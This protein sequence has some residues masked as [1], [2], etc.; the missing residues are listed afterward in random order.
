MYF[1]VTVGQSR[2]G[3]LN[4]SLPRHTAA[5]ASRTTWSCH[6][7]GTQ[8]SPLVSSLGYGATSE[9]SGEESADLLACLSACS[10]VSL[11][12]V[13]PARSVDG[14]HFATPWT[15]SIIHQNRLLPSSLLSPFSW[16]QTRGRGC[17]RVTSGEPMADKLTN[18]LPRPQRL[19]PIRFGRSLRIHNFHDHGRLSLSV[20]GSCCLL[21]D[22]VNS[23][24]GLLKLINWII[25]W[26]HFKH[27]RTCF[28]NGLHVN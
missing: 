17:R 13:A 28:N 9:T 1:S 6:R 12:S 14:Y 5:A 24:Q 21:C 23:H 10:P 4:G 16:A 25:H 19:R 3:T 20:K 18:Q 8:F 27:Y 15:P 22:S 26:W 2:Q 11:S 7:G